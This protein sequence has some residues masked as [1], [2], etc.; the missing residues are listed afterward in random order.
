MEPSQPGAHGSQTLASTCLLQASATGGG[1]AW[2][3]GALRRLPA[4]CWYS[5][6]SPQNPG[7]GL[8]FGYRR[9]RDLGSERP[10]DLIRVTH[11][12][13]PGSVACGC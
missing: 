4:P 12:L 1:R 11:A 13:V 10:G 2:G 6:S 3:L 8:V 9:R 7:V 5:V